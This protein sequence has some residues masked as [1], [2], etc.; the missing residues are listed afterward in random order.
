MTAYSKWD[1]YLA[2]VRFEDIDESKIRPVLIL[3]DNEFMSV[4]CIKMTGQ[5][6]RTGEYVL[7]KWR[8]AGLRKPTVVRIGKKIRLSKD[9]FIMRIGRL[10]VIDIVAIEQLLTV[11]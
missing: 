11:F 3:G 6:P 9:D 4:D 2:N 5:M 1:I 10:D 8:E 7:Q